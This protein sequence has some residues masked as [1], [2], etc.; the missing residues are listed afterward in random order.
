MGRGP[1]IFLVAG[2]HKGGNQERG[3]HTHSK[4]TEESTDQ[5]HC[6]MRCS[7]LHGASKNSN[8]CCNHESFLPS[9]TITGPT[10]ENGTEKP[11]SREASVHGTN[12]AIGIIIQSC[13]C[14]ILGKIEILEETRLTEGC[15]YN[16]EGVAICQTTKAKR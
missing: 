7:P 3:L 9:K 12:D 6:N 15:G 14:R 1:L 13:I 5:E 11:A 2:Q 4:A 10:N 8:W 16:A